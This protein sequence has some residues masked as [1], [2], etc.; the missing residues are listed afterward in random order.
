LSGSLEVYCSSMYNDL[1]KVIV[2]TP[3]F[4]Y[5]DLLRIP[6]EQT[7]NFDRLI[8]AKLTDPLF[9]EALYW[10]SPEIFNL[11]LQWK[12]G[13]LKAGKQ[14]NK[15][16]HSLKKYI[17]RAGSRATP[18]GVF[19]GCAAADIADGYH[20]GLANEMVAVS[21]RRSIRLDMRVIGQLIDHIKQDETLIQHLHYHTNSSVYEVH[22]HY[23][24]LEYVLTNGQREYQLTSI[25]KSEVLDNV[26]Q[27]AKQ[28]PMR[29]DDLFKVI[30]KVASEDEKRDFVQE[31]I[32]SQF[33]VAEIEVAVTAKDP[34][35]KLRSFFDLLAA[36]D[37][38]HVAYLQLVTTIS[39]L[40]AECE[41]A[42]PGN[43]P[44]D[45]ISL[46]EKQLADL[47]IVAEGKV[48]LQADLFRPAASVPQVT[49]A[50][51]SDLLEASSMVS[52][53]SPKV[54]LHEQRLKDFKK[55]FIEK[56]DTQEIPFAE[57]SD[58]EMGIG[59]P[60]AQPI[61]NVAYN[62]FTEDIKSAPSSQKPE[63]PQ[64]WHEFLHTKIDLAN[65]A[66]RGGIV[67]NSDELSAFSGKMQQLSGTVAI[68][69]SVLPDGKLLWNSTGGATAN[70]LIGRFAY[71]DEGIEQ[72]CKS[73]AQQDSQH[74]A[75]AIIAEI[76]HL[77]EGKVGNVIRRLNV[78]AYE[79]PFLSEPG[80]D[81]D[82]VIS[83]D[84]LM[85]SV[86]YDKVVL[87]SRKLNKVIVPRLSCAH[88]YASS[89]LSAYQLLCALQH[90][91]KTGLNISLG[92]WSRNRKYFPRIS[93]G[94]VILSLASWHFKAQEYA[95][96]LSSVNPIS[97]LR[98]FL[99][100]N[101][102]PQYFALS[103]GDNE[104]F[105]DLTEDT[106]LEILL[107]E[108]KRRKPVKFIEWLHFDAAAVGT[109]TV[110]QYVLPLYKIDKALPGSNDLELYQTDQSV[111]RAFAP[112][113]EWVY[114]KFYCGA[115]LSDQILER[116]VKPVSEELLSR[117]LADQF[118]FIRYND[119][120][121]HIRYRVHLCEQHKHSFTEVM[122][123]VNLALEPFLNNRTVWKV[124]LDTYQ[125]ELERYGAQRISAT[126]YLFFEDS[127]L[128]LELLCSG[129]F[130]NNE[131][132]RMYAALKNVDHWL[133]LFELDLSE[134]VLF[135]TQM[136]NVLVKEFGPDCKVKA[137]LKY[138]ELKTDISEYMLRS[139]FNALFLGRGR[140]KA[141]LSR[142]NLAS[143][144]HMSINRWFKT[145]QRL[146]EYCV[147]SFCAKYY[148]TIYNNNNP[149]LK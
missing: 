71:L 98:D 1:G 75:E 65:P 15:Y 30:G 37:S 107:E 23:R 96:V 123:A 137:D 113:S 12:K 54:S 21:P 26:F 42:E 130:L 92:E 122:Q 52:L 44:L 17:I 104:L 124:Q 79:I 40:L 129:A 5:E 11:S 41:A 73:I 127:H 18:Y 74:Q 62:P 118:F 80:V 141:D 128:Y 10:A 36:K 131:N 31:L 43:L 78:N 76:A 28:G 58:L 88:N 14:E 39:A 33:L 84:D 16:L 45:K 108:L 144:I 135:T 103:E 102:M 138:R 46:L 3:L 146:M 6:G 101:Q 133:E 85:L 148:K 50:M 134:K 57:V 61:G 87:R 132:N 32:S 53:F 19:A 94:R 34:L 70:S 126:E 100:S 56:Y 22:G 111:K 48:F 149:V 139:E 136:A 114:F 99:D 20:A 68:L 145:E 110:N 72:L 116:L 47:G 9:M 120:N 117:H 93:Y 82:H 24:Y 63:V 77:P 109:K 66:D 29:R 51:V 13:L 95:Y 91:G 69:F 97:A 49:A 105:F 55:S 143:Y 38:R 125:R 86:Q 67:L 83:L 115:H 140:K 35:L 25:E 4:S 142:E 147:Y 64:K 119:P 81:A 60:V 27:A 90:Q 2:R 121:Y 59:F 112:G 7:F 8:A 89:D 106:Y